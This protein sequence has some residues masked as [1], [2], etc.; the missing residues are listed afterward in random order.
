M[1]K[2]STL[3]III[4]GLLFISH[5]I[6]KAGELADSLRGKILLQVESNGEAWYVKPSDSKKIYLKDGDVAYNVMRDLGLGI[7]NSDLFKIPIGFEDRFESPVLV[8]IFPSTDVA[9]LKIT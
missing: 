8:A 7:S 6:T 5:N 9:A 2:I 1:K 4:M 3:I